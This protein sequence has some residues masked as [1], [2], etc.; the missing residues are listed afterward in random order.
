[1]TFIEKHKRAEKYYFFYF[2]TYRRQEQV[3]KKFS[4]LFF[5]ISK[6]IKTMMKYGTTEESLLEEFKK[7]PGI[8]RMTAKVKDIS[9][10]SYIGR[11]GSGRYRFYRITPESAVKTSCINKDV[12]SED[13]DS[14]TVTFREYLDILGTRSVQGTKY[15][16]MIFRWNGIM[17]APGTSRT[18]KNVEKN[19]KKNLTG[20]FCGTISD[21]MRNMSAA[22][23]MIDI[24]NDVAA[25]YRVSESEDGIIRP[26]GFVPVPWASYTESDARITKEQ[27]AE[28]V[29][30]LV[31]ED[32]RNTFGKKTSE[33]MLSGRHVSYQHGDIRVMVIPP[34]EME[35][36]HMTRCD[37]KTCGFIAIDP[38]ISEYMLY[39]NGDIKTVTMREETA[40]KFDVNEE[41]LE[42][43]GF[44][45]MTKDENGRNAVIKNGRG[46]M[47]NICRI[48]GIKEKPEDGMS[49]I[50]DLMIA[51]GLFNNTKN[52]SISI[53]VHDFPVS[54]KLRLCRGIKATREEKKEVDFTKA[55]ETVTAEMT[56]RNFGFRSWRK[57]ETDYT[58][59]FV[60]NGN[61][62]RP[63]RVT[64]GKYGDVTVGA[65]LQMSEEAG[66]SYRL[67]GVFYCGDSVFYC[68][69]DTC[70]KGEKRFGAVYSQRKNGDE[71]AFVKLV[72]GFFY[73][74]KYG[75]KEDGVMSPWEYLLRQAGLADGTKSVFDIMAETAPD[76]ETHEMLS[77]VNGEK[78]MSGKGYEIAKKIGKKKI[79]RKT[80]GISIGTG[81]WTKLDTV[82]L[83]VN[84]SEN[85]KEDIGRKRMTMECIGNIIAL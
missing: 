47:G 38:R 15:S 42:R 20:P 43:D 66:T 65:E 5:G 54:G 44:L 28:K 39:M 81:N 62:G 59:S 17:I 60:L 68:G 7:A 84:L 21:E 31:S 29:W 1:M 3:L 64:A 22:I 83:L 57:D 61:D 34:S 32:M 30:R 73:G 33:K 41:T 12:V 8:T 24:E 16:G 19:M 9:I 49:H 45:I 85:E 82:M 53:M 36:L 74:N 40:E 50:R 71:Y 78:Q 67:C 14:F 70:R 2:L 52:E 4:L 18:G 35:V 51:R 69:D 72:N 55:V 23:R 56:A 25:Y 6:E 58:V 63:V 10:L 27:K 37:R 76:E 46:F 13:A 26:I 79:A 48:A 11:S 80:Y 77:I 75:V